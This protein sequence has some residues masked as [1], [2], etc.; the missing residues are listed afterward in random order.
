MDKKTAPDTRFSTRSRSVFAV[1]VGPPHPTISNSVDPKNRSPKRK[2][3]RADRPTPGGTYVFFGRS[4]RSRR[5][6]KKVSATRTGLPAFLVVSLEFSTFLFYNVISI[7]II[8]A[9][10]VILSKSIIYSYY[11]IR[12]IFISLYCIGNSY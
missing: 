5:R 7:N 9:L 3:S 12:F 6:V 1:S 10:V 8:P 4:R 2:R 11:S